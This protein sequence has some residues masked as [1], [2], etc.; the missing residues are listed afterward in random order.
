MTESRELAKGLGLV[1][2]THM[3]ANNQSTVTSLPKDLIPTS[4]LSRHQACM[5]Y[6]YICVGKTHIINILF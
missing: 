1:P 4:G 6:P 2:S 3:V 5:W